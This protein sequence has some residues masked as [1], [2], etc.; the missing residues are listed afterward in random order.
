V[1]ENNISTYIE[2]YNKGN[3]KTYWYFILLLFSIY[4][5]GFN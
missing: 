5:S 2:S 1:S 3:L 4:L